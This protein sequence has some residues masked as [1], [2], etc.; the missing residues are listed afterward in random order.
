[1]EWNE[2][3]HELGQN[4]VGQCFHSFPVQARDGEF[5]PSF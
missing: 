1:M 3:V 4:D 2:R 5:Q